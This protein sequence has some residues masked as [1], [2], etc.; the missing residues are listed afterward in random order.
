MIDKCCYNKDLCSLFKCQIHSRKV[1]MA[2][3]LRSNGNLDVDKTVLHCNV[4]RKICNNSD[5]EALRVHDFYGRDKKYDKLKI[6][7]LKNGKSIETKNLGSLKLK[8]EFMLVK[9]EPGQYDELKENLTTSIGKNEYKNKVKN[10]NEVEVEHVCNRRLLCKSDSLFEKSLSSSSIK[11]RVPA[12]NASNPHKNCSMDEMKTKRN[13]YMNDDS[14]SLFSEVKFGTVYTCHLCEYV[15]SNKYSLAKHKR[16]HN[17]CQYCK[18]KFKSFK[19]LSNHK[20]NCNFEKCLKSCPKV[21]LS[22]IAF[23]KK[24][25]SLYHST[26]NR[27]KFPPFE[28][29]SVFT[30]KEECV[31]S[32][33]HI[34]QHLSVKREFKS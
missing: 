30:I 8:A 21:N 5:D 33:I 3:T 2:P 6:E 28:S 7:M 4:P 24:I 31:D 9:S 13:S 19:A 22:N 11:H 20:K 12:S 29:G 26:F 25:R 27:N 23:S 15:F 32:N 1:I 34:T 16:K 14:S 18:T 17:F 10:E